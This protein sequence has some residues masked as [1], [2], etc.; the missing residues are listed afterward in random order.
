MASWW[1]DLRYGVRMLVKSP[2]FTFV[3]VVALALGI[4]ANTAIFS[5]VNAVLLRP[6]PFVNAEQLVKVYG[7]RARGGTGYTPVSYPDFADYKKQ[8]QS[9][10][11]VASYSLA[12]T[13]LMSGGDEPERLDGAVV[14]AELFPMLDA[15]P[16][17]GRVFS[18][19]EDQPGAAPVIV[20]SYGLWQR[21][22][23]SDPKIS[24]Q[25][26]II[27]GRTATVLGVMPADFKFP[28]QAERVDYWSPLSSDPGIAPLLTARGMRF[29]PVIASLK[30][31][32]TLRQAEAEMNTLASQLAAQYPETNTGGS[33]HL[34]SLHEDL[35][36]DIRPA[37]LVLLGAVGFVLLIACANVANLS[38]ARA[39]ARSKEIAIRTALGASR[40]RVVRQLLTESLLLSLCGGALG[41]M[42]ALWGV[43]LL[44]ALS[45]PD[46]PRLAEIGIDA[47]V[48]VFTLG[49]S[50]LTG[51]VFGI[52]PAL[53]ISKHDLNESLKEGGR[54]ST[55][56]L[57][58]NRV[59]SLLV[60]SEV[61]LSLMLLVGAGL[62][63]KSFLRL[64]ETNPGY[65]TEHVLAADIALSRTRYPEPT[66][67]A[68]FFQQAI[69]RVASLPGVEAV[70]VT[71]LLPLGGADARI[72]FNIDGRPSFPRGE[73]PAAR[74]QIASPDYFRVMNIPLHK[75]RSFTEQDAK[76]SPPVVIVSEAF[77]RRF[78]AD[79]DPIGKRVLIDTVEKNPPPSEII[80]VVGD[81]RH[82]RLDAKT[83]M[84]FYVPYLQSPA[85]NMELVTRSKS[86]EPSLLTSSVRGVIKEIDKN[87]LIWEM[88]MMSGLVAR[89][90][91][92]QRFNM[93][94]LGIFAFVALVLAACGIYGVIAYSVAQRT[95]EI[96]I[97]M[98]LG[99]QPADVLRL[100]VG[101]GMMLALI[102]VGLGLLGAFALTRVIASQ[103]YGVSATDPLTFAIVAIML[104]IVAL[105]ACYIPAR[106]A[107]KVDPMIALRYE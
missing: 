22:F 38:L 77:A 24:G 51:I 34:E 29:L 87:Q 37:L 60:V 49:V 41:L 73:T 2:G 78:F 28:V 18:A 42:L 32:I 101:Q 68:A 92:P 47:R 35:V 33:V 14:S 50:I 80:G 1:Q 43:D 82:G 16:A 66:Q 107:T 6:L 4:G 97:R 64:L 72:S 21:R 105:A 81:V 93:L 58:R 40:M 86:I 46:V 5:V 69:Q 27:G 96:G 95:H 48:L 83:E 104:A 63:I 23:N 88:R 39:A 67:Q 79:E 62:L 74:Y 54:G 17:L 31:N 61:A 98:A 44:I 55:E 26:I 20:L 91:A 85:R 106:R 56:G 19:E 103:L 11:R 25:E 99:A 70:G 15:K 84:G 94:L 7:G 102:G 65:D 36:G 10:D 12:G 90:V 52:A 9:F 57:R 53:Q 100:I 30:P 8:A 13:T 59:R 3:A 45:P 76:D 75:G 71:N 89:S